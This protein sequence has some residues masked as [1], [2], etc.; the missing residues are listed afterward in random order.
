MHLAIHHAGHDPH[1]AR[2]HAVTA[3]GRHARA[4]LRDAAVTHR[5]PTVHRHPVRVHDIAAHHQIEFAHYRFHPVLCAGSVVTAQ[6]KR[7]MLICA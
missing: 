7:L 5:Q 2:V 1:A 3:S 4:P 6:A